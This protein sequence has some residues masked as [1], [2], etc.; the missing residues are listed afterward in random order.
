[1]AHENNQRQDIYSLGFDRYLYR[2]VPERKSPLVYDFFNQ[3]IEAIVITQSG[4][5][6]LDTLFTKGLK[7]YNFQDIFGFGDGA[8][9]D[10]VIKTDTT[11]TRDMY[12]KNLVI[13]KGVVLTP[14][15]F[16]IF[17]SENLLV[18]GTIRMN[19]KDGSAGKAGGDQFPRGGAGGDAITGGYLGDT[20]P[21][22][23]GANTETSSSPG[24][25]ASHALGSNG[26][27]GGQGGASGDN[28][29]KTGNGGDPGN[30]IAPNVQLKIN[31]NLL[32]MLD[33]NADGST[34]K[35]DYNGQ[36][37]GGGGGESSSGGRS[38]GGGGGAGSEGGC[39]AIYAKKITITE[40][41]VIEANGGN[42]G[43]GGNGQSNQ[44]GANGAGG[45]GGGA[46]GNGGVILLVYN[47]IINYGTIQAKGGKGG[48]GGAGG[49][50]P[51]SSGSPGY[52]GNSGEDGNSGK[53][54]QF[55]IAA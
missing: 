8:D 14:A 9:G 42:G 49:N 52:D 37:T 33:V 26:A 46:G 31:W 35:Y 6:F 44:G 47:E 4:N 30:A 45:G 36:S 19:G 16:R 48:Q 13:E 29:G 40:T 55:Q 10:V 2:Q 28:L 11:L 18:K 54:I 38:G 24:T 20:L 15:H 32:S 27:R 25:D 3:G 7:M 17:V 41:G 21:G 5:L 22:G 39:I 34:V 12:Y 43:K 53:I 51:A 1:M 23:D 50:D